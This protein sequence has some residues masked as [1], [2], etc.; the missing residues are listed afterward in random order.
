LKQ[1]FELRSPLGNAGK[2]VEY[3]AALNRIFASI[4]LLAGLVLA[5]SG[6]LGCSY[7][8]TIPEGAVRCDESQRCPA[9]MM[10]NAVRE[11]A[12]VALVCCRTLGCPGRPSG[13]GASIVVPPDEPPDL[14]LEPTTPDLR[15]GQSDD[16]AL[17]PAEDP[18]AGR[19]GDAS[20]SPESSPGPATPAP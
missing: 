13:T 2:S 5:G 14:T 4:T 20:F 11:G 7:Q 3:S 15:P 18:S 8:P 12:A 9:G 19:D 1:T 10:C 16:P 6:F 17:A